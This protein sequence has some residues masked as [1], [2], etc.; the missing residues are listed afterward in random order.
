MKLPLVFMILTLSAP[1]TFLSQTPPPP[2]RP[3]PPERFTIIGTPAVKTIDTSEHG[4]RAGF[5]SPPIKAVKQ[6][7]TA[8]GKTD[9]TTFSVGTALAHY[10]VTYFDFPAVITDEQELRL[11]YDMART[12][13]ERSIDGRLMS[14]QDIYFGERFGRE[15]VIEG[16]DATVTTRLFTAQQRVFQ[17]TVVSK[18]VLS[19]LSEKSQVSTRSL[20]TKFF[21]SFAVTNVPPP[22]LAAAELPSDPGVKVEDQTFTST[23]LGMSMKLPKNWIVLDRGQTDLLVD[24]GAQEAASTKPQKAVAMDHSLKNTKILVFATNKS[25]ENDVATAYL[26]VSIERVGFPNFLPDAVINTFIAGTLDDD[27][28]VTKPASS[29]KLDGISF[30]WLEYEDPTKL[31]SRFYIA[32]RHGIALEILFSYRTDEELVQLM[33]SLGSIRFK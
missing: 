24:V 20:V 7:D 28:R 1:A 27:E 30:S 10:S 32:N 15:Y 22:A 2:P 6:I 16:K 29:T 4:F 26:S 31:R 11:R 5:P 9:M 23:F 18:G 21:D 3:A 13:L 19:K 25:I 8:F 14:E 17:L 33:D 12:N